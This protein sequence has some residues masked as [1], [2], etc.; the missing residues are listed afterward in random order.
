M[1]LPAPLAL[2]RQTHPGVRVDVDVIESNALLDKLLRAGLDFFV[3][4]YSAVPRHKDLR[5]E[6]LG[7]L[8]LSFFCRAAHPLAARGAVGLDE[9]S[10]YRLAS[11]HIPDAVLKNLV[12]RLPG[13]ADVMPEL[14]LQCGSLTILRDYVL[15][16]DAVLLGTARPFRVELEQGLLVPLRVWASITSHS[17]DCCDL[18]LDRCGGARSTARFPGGQG[19]T[20]RRSTFHQ[21]IGF[22]WH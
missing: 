2:L 8:H 15:G 4:E 16:S 14:S 5:I 13:G 6:P 12:D 1:V 7:R 22:A 19:D 20:D 9:L 3:G 10:G 17:V 18:D 21:V 11:V